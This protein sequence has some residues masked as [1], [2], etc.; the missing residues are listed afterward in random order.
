MEITKTD[1]KSIIANQHK[2]LTQQAQLSELVQKTFTI[3]AEMSGTTDIIKQGLNIKQSTSGEILNR[4]AQMHKLSK[5]ER[6]ELNHI[7]GLQQSLDTFNINTSFLERQL[8][9]ESLNDS[10]Y[11]K[12]KTVI[13][14]WMPA[15]KSWGADEDLTMD[16]A[17]E[18]LDKQKA[19][20]S[21]S[22]TEN[23]EPKERVEKEPISEN[24]SNLLKDLLEDS[25]IKLE[26]F[27]RNV[28]QSVVQWGQ[29][30]TKQMN[31]IN[32]ALDK[33]GVLSMS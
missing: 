9:Y 7:L 4:P 23:G 2:L 13:E 3:M 12:I 10:Q 16:L 21:K 31:I 30:S 27:D 1:A 25:D 8:S 19:R 18:A 28:I 29:A 22:K 33:T 15:V 32:K 14:D 11:E 24:L 17:R 5:E 20:N 6:E 26:Q